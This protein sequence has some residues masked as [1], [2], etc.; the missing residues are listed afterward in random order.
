MTKYTEREIEDLK[1]Q[2][3]LLEGR[4][5]EERRLMAESDSKFYRVGCS[6]NNSGGAFW[7]KDR[8]YEAMDKAGFDIIRDVEK[9]YYRRGFAVT[10]AAPNEKIA[11]FI[12][13]EKFYDA[14]GFTGDEQGCNCCGQ[15]FYFE[16]IASDKTFWWEDVSSDPF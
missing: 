10:V 3:A 14:T 9:N 13:K 7:L 2:V 4:L 6:E 11:E 16:V 8:H 15:P 1:E 12:A 5:A